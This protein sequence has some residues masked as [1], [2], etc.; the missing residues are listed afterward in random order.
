MAPCSL[1]NAPAASLGCGH[2]ADLASVNAGKGDNEAQDHLPADASSDSSPLSQCRSRP[3]RN[4]GEQR[5][6]EGEGGEGAPTGMRRQKGAGQAG[7]RA[8]GAS[9]DSRGMVYS[10]V[11]NMIK[12]EE[13]RRYYSQVR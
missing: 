7:K 1:G 8:E 11:G 2:S 13:G 6:G 3:R 10:W 4:N 5:L 9:G 12:V